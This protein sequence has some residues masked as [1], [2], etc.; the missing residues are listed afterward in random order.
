MLKRQKSWTKNSVNYLKFLKKLNAKTC[1]LSQLI[2][3]FIIIQLR[4]INRVRH[5][6]KATISRNQFTTANRT[7][8]RAHR[9][10]FPAVTACKALQ[11]FRVRATICPARA[12]AC[13]AQVM[14]RRVQAMGRRVQAMG[15]LV[16]VPTI[17][18]PLMVQ[19][20]QPMV[21]LLTTRLQRQLCRS[22]NSSKNIRSHKASGSLLSWWKSST[23]FLCPRYFWNWSFS[24]KS[25]RKEDNNLE[26]PIIIWSNNS[27][28]HRRD[29]LVDVHPC[30]EEEIHGS[31]GRD[32]RRRR[33]KD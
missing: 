15:L 30:A 5:Q 12:I 22:P 8:M 13:L 29:L 20:I 1:R 23:W 11:A 4:R 6:T 3:Q 21:T 24:R 16:S 27:Q 2:I 18:S 26:S 10:Q 28:I 31:F 7:I 19:L 25:V 32:G 33:T 17:H 14:G 9:S